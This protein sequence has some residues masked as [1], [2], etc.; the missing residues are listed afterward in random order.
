[1]PYA[2]WTPDRL[3]RS[4]STLAVG[5]VLR[6]STTVYAV[7]M[8]VTMALLYYAGDVNADDD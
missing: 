2:G 6:E 4:A 5:V 8:G 1:M 3:E 7:A